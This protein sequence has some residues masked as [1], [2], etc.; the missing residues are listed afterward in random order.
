MIQVVGSLPYTDGQSVGDYIC[1]QV[2]WFTPLPCLSFTGTLPSCATISTICSCP[3]YLGC[4]KSVWGQKAAA[5]GGLCV[6]QTESGCRTDNL[7][8]GALW[9]TQGLWRRW[10]RRKCECQLEVKVLQ[11]TPLCL[12][13]S[14]ID[15]RNTSWFFQI[16]QHK[17][18]LGWTWNRF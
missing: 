9:R 18:C 5:T 3:W 6:F 17:S 1:S 8:I 2:L 4:M 7:W 15:F 12:A 13:V 14:K 10:I 16:L 11:W